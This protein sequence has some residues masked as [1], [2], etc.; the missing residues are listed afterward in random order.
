M[1]LALNL[2]LDDLHRPV[3]PAVPDRIRIAGLTS[4][5][6]EVKPGYLFFALP[7]THRD[8]NVYIGHALKQGACAIVSSEP[9]EPSLISAN[10][11]AAFISS[12]DIRESMAVLSARFYGTDTD[13]LKIIGITGTN[14][15][16]T[17]AHILNCMIRS[18]GQETILMGTIGIE[19]CGEKIPTDYTTPPPYEI[20]R[21]IRTGADA[22]A[23]WVIMEVSSHALKLRRVAGMRFDCAIFTNLTHEHREIHPTMEDYYET[24][25]GLFRMLK[26]GGMAVINAD[27]PYG[28]RLIRD[29]GRDINVA[30]YGFQ[31]GT[32]VMERV[33]DDPDRFMQIIGLRFGEN[34]YSLEL[35]I[36]G[37][38]NAYNGVAAFAALHG[39]GFDSSRL[40]GQFS[41]IRAPEGR[42]QRY[43]AGDIHAVIDFAHTPD[44]L[45][46]ILTA[47][48]ALMKPG[49]RLIVAFG[50]PGDRDKSKRPLMGRIAGQIADLVFA[51]SDDPHFEDPRAVLRDII[52]GTDRTKVRP[53]VDRREAIHTALSEARAGDWIVIAGRGHERFQYIGDEKVP[54]HDEQVFTE[55][56][57]RMGLEVTVC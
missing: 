34:H 42:F 7:G 22:G 28:Q 15:K 27:D 17:I 51:T 24:K 30:D 14:G 49:C 16:S 13:R 40:A 11:G 10:P 23:G 50:C 41:F 5:S 26:P 6:R 32:C 8:G 18:Q 29:H 44:G 33:T 48:R 19:I 55:E 4:D 45:E 2:L 39:F 35:G 57:R 25:S 9:F 1:E 52:E 12:P 53:I 36:P 38:Y 54:F 43:L 31:A 46:K 20:H 56:A 47:V 37:L 3:N 21:F